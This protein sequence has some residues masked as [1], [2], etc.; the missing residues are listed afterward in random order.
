MP[1]YPDNHDVAPLIT[2]V[3]RERNWERYEKRREALQDLSP[4]DYAALRAEAIKLQEPWEDIG[5]VME[6]LVRRRQ[7]RH[8][9]EKG[10]KS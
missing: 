5:E 3:E 2:L 6:R 7:V 4:A 1:S 10:S 9:L 8:L